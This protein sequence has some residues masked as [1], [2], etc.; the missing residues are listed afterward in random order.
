MANLYGDVNLIETVR[1]TPEGKVEKVYRI[2]ARTKSGVAFAID[3]VEAE[4]ETKKVDQLLLQ[5]ATQ[6]EAIKAL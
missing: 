3:V 2:S 1:I 5:K 6:I 4:L